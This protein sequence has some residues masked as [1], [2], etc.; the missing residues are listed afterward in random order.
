MTRSLAVF[1]YGYKPNSSFTLLAAG[2][3]LKLFNLGYF[4][5]NSKGP[6]Q[7]SIPSLFPNGADNNDHCVALLIGLTSSFPSNVVVTDFGD[8]DNGNFQSLM[9]PLAATT[10]HQGQYGSIFYL[11]LETMLAWEAWIG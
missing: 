9:N 11:H 5:D 3:N 8:S 7:T 1:V 10:S 2:Y 6:D 4:Q